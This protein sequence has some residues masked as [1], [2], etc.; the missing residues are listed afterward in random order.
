VLLLSCSSYSRYQGESNVG[1]DN[2]TTG[3]NDAAI[4][5]GCLFPGEVC[6]GGYCEVC[7]G[8]YC[9]ASFLIVQ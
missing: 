8:G 7:F 2:A 5:Y 6:F 4:A 9:E 3:E 1:A